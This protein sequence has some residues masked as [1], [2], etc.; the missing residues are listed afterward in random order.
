V[1]RTEGVS[2]IR[3]AAEHSIEPKSHE[4]HA[5]APRPIAPGDL[6]AWNGYRGR[7]RAVNGETA[8][9]IERDNRLFGR[10]VTWHLRL[11]ALTGV[12]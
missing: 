10:T 1:Q 7:V 6:V 9:V 4:S 2:R 8:V 5:S 3:V 11:N 12:P